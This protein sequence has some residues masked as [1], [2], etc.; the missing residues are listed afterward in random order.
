MAVGC[1]AQKC[2]AVALSA[3]LF[4]RR[5][6][7]DGGEAGSRTH[8]RRGIGHRRDEERS[9]LLVEAL[10]QQRELVAKQRKAVAGGPAQ[11]GLGRRRGVRQHRDHL[12]QMRLDDSR[13]VLA[14]G[15]DGNEGGM[16]RRPRRRRL[17]HALELR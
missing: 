7:V 14:D 6:E 8:A 1:G 12:R 10:W 2:S 4:H 3:H 17:E 11:P 16:A 5:A 15:G 13:A 9:E